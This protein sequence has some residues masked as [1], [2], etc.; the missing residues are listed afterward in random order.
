MTVNDAIKAL[1][2]LRAEGCGEDTLVV[3]LNKEVTYFQYEVPRPGGGGRPRTVMVW[4]EDFGLPR[5]S[6]KAHARELVA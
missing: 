3:D 2:R 1:E 5:G 6:M 4:D